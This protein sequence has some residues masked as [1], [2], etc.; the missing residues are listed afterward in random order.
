[1]LDLV[2]RLKGGQEG[3]SRSE[4]QLSHAILADLDTA[5]GA[6]IV[7]LAARAEVSPSTVTR[8]CRRL[9]CESFSAF[10]VRLAQ[11]HVF[12][13]RYLEPPAGPESVPDIARSVVSN[14]Q[15]TLDELLDRID[16]RAVEGAAAAIVKAGY[17]IAFGSGGASSMIALELENRLFRLGLKASATLDHQAQLMRA[18]G[19][20]E[21]TVVVASSM[22]GRNAPLARALGVAG[23]YG[24]TRVA[25][26]RPGTPVAAES[27]IVLGL[28]FRENGDILQPT[29]ARFGFLAAIDVLAQTVATRM[30][31][32][33]VAAMRRIKHQLVVNRDG[34]DDGQALGD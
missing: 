21:G 22:S 17:V 2:G 29:A 28:D 32:P 14:A 10:K 34:G 25:L 12:G 6:S 23:S 9:G 33:A 18:A 5:L 4:R 7:D 8:F 31:G 30:Q 26:T 11:S 20:P 3:F 24:L 15:N 1:M 16:E 19:A 27:D 13:R